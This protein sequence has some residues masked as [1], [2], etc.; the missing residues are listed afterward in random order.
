MKSDF[1]FEC[2][3]SP[4]ILLKRC[5]VIP[6]LNFTHST[7]DVCLSSFVFFGEY[8][9]ALRKSAQN[10]YCQL[11]EHK[12]CE[13]RQLATPPSL[14]FGPLLHFSSD[15]GY[16][17]IRGQCTVDCLSPLQAF[18]LGEISSAWFRMSKGFFDRK[19]R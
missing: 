2:D 14:A 6:L 17:E 4:V 5:L 15:L 19:K 10:Q 8:K 18:T 13:M 9:R 11:E 12:P 16:L 7:L 1:N 3:F